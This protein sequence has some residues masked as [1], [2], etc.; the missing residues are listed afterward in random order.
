MISRF[1]RPLL[2]APGDLHSRITRRL[3]TGAPP[4]KLLF[5]GGDAFSVGVLEPILAARGDDLW[6]DLIVVTSGEKQVG[7]GS[8]GTRRI[9][10]ELPY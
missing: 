4:L 8:K 6:S 7:R 1:R 9:V 5:L 10:R 2:G 3:S